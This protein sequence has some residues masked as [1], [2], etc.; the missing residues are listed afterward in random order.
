[1]TRQEYEDARRDARTIYD[2]AK[3][4]AERAEG[5]REDMEF[6]AICLRNF[7]VIDSLED[8]CSG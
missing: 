3:I 6:L 5:S 7:R 1:M 8:V 2:I 4:R